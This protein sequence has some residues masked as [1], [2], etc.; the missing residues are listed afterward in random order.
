MSA[1]KL[2]ASVSTSGPTKPGA[3][4]TLQYWTRS[5]AR[6]GVQPRAENV[7]VRGALEQFLCGTNG[8]YRSKEKNTVAGLETKRQ[9]IANQGL[10]N[11]P[12]R[13]EYHYQRTNKSC[14]TVRNYC[15]KTHPNPLHRG[16]PAITT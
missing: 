11:F 16:H 4:A 9:N 1:D 3:S 6:N 7:I 8:L 14:R 10:A 5:S 2:S 15:S 12:Y 13:S